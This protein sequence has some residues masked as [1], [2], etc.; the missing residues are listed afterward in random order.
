MIEGEAGLAVYF[1]GSW[2]TMYYEANDLAGPSAAGTTYT[3]QIHVQLHGVQSFTE[4]DITFKNPCFDR[5]YYDII[6]LPDRKS[7]V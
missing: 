2:L 5:N 4:V 3:V 6:P 7:V 1:D